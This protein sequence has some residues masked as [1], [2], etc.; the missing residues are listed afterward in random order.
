[1]LL[2]HTVSEKVKAFLAGLLD[3]G[4]RLIQSEP[5]SGDRI[6][7]PLQCFRRVATA[8][9]HEV[10]SVVDHTSLKLLSPFGDAPVLEK[11]IH[12]QVREHRADNS[13]L[14]SPAAALLS[15]HHSSLPLLVSF[16]HRNFQP[17]LT[18]IRWSM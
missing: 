1:M 14:G 8:Q 12:V 5:K 2:Q 6:P 13:A 11:T 10:V 17:H 16:F 18:I 9:N 7:R 4:F 3:A 15:S